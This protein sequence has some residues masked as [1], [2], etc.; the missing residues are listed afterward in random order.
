MK[1]GESQMM[2]TNIHSHALPS[3]MVVAFLIPA[4]CNLQ[5]DNWESHLQHQNQFLG[6]IL[7]VPELIKPERER[8][9]NEC[10]GWDDSYEALKCTPLLLPVI[11]T[12][13]W[14]ESAIDDACGIVEN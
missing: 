1:L 7:W 3:S 14:L 2:F 4:T 13:H 6:F 9:N 8:D 5:Q 11:T 12:W 10:P